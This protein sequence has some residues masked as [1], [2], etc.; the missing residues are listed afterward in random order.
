M[1]AVD[2]HGYDGGSN[3]NDFCGQ[4][5][6]LYGNEKIRGESLVLKAQLS[7]IQLHYFFFEDQDALCI[8][9][10]YYYEIDT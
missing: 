5:V 8:I 3:V 7:I 9:S 6:D 1:R 2:W 4:T 10:I